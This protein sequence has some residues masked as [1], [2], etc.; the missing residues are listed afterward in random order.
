MSASRLPGTSAPPRKK[1]GA[2]LQEA[3]AT[4]RGEAARAARSATF[5]VAP[6][7]AGERL[8]SWLARQDG[9]PTRSQIK[10]AADDDRLTIDGKPVR[11]SHRLRE[12]E[13]VTL[14]E[15]EP[16]PLPPPS[17]G[18][19]IDLVVLHEDEWFLAIDKP[20]GLVV[21]P[22]AG[23]PAGTLVDALRAREPSRAW[24]GDASRAGIVHRLDRE[25]S[26][27]ILV[28]KTVAAHEALSRQ[29]RDRTIRKTYL[30]IV[31][32]AVKEPGHIDLAIGRHPTERTKMSVRGRPARASTTDYRPLERVGPATLLEVHP[33]TGRT[34]QIRVHLS[35]AGFP[36]VSDPV[37]GG[38][39]IGGLKRH[40]LHASAIELAHPAGGGHL[41]IEA[42]LPRDLEDLLAWLRASA[43]RGG[44]GQ[45]GRDRG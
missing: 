36:I 6:Q 28:A 18:D 21:H 35:A 10:A 25:T 31:H 29:F 26:G 43:D 39:T 16:A 42:P 14:L 30:A 24:P 23:N 38:R 9:A 3:A 27:V 11:A 13:S 7:Y 4:S 45:G 20:A 34:H 41:R 17:S 2:A 12:G 15:A 33:R 40:A 37:Y 5:F 32:G 1:A 19:A 8:D 44:K 22:G